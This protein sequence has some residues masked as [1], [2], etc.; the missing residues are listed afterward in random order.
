VLVADEMGLGK[1]IQAVGVI[2][3]DPVIG[4]VLIVCPGS[5]RI[6]WR[7]A[8]EQWLVR[9]MNAG[10]VGVDR[11]TGEELFLHS[12]VVIINYDRLHTFKTLL[13]SCQ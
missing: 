8:L 11:L 13:Q 6:P 5:M 3:A 4:K 1:T 7:R 12:E 2:D 9:P 10:V